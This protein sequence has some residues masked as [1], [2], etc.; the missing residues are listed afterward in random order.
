MAV[1]CLV[2]DKFRSALTYNAVGCE[3]DVNEP[4]T[5]FKQ[6][7]FRQTYKSGLYIDK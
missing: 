3:F 2:L 5:Y 7:V 1:M 4:T 6:G